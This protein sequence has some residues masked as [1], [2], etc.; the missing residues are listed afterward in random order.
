MKQVLELRKSRNQKEALDDSLAKTCI[1]YNIEISAEKTKLM[2]NINND[3]QR[4]VKVKRQKLSTVT[5]F[6]HFEAVVSYDGS[7]PEILPRIEQTIAAFTKLDPIIQIYISWIK[8]ETN[9]LPSHFHIS[10]YFGIMDL[11]SRV[12]ET[13]QVFEMRCYRRLLRKN[14]NLRWFSQGA[15]NHPEAPHDTHGTP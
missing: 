1:W 3:I 5:S 15:T 8:G 9:V 12:R 2:T 13:M 6:K 11:D 7:K 14:K 10:V 4:E